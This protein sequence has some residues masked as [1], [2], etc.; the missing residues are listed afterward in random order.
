LGEDFQPEIIRN[1]FVSNHGRAIYCGIFTNAKIKANEIN[2]NKSG[3][4][5][6]SSDTLIFLNKI[7]HNFG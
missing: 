4:F 5:C 1:N 2:N 6:T 7:N 3:I